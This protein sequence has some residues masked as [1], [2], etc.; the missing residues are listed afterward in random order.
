MRPLH[1]AVA[2]LEHRSGGITFEV[3]VPDAPPL[4]RLRQLGWLAAIAVAYLYVFPYFPRIQ[5]ANELPRAYLVKAIA[6]DHTFAI[7]KDVARWGGTADVSPSGGH[8]YSNKAPGA[9]LIV[10]PV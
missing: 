9:S 8:Q 4:Q 6:D 5:S 10:V 3:D 2:R 1:C 7:D